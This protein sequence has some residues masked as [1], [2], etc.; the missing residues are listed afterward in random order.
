MS[1][2]PMPTAITADQYDSLLLSETP[3]I[4]LRA[5]VEFAK[6]AF[7]GSVSLP[8][9]TDQER[10][11]IGTRYKEQGQDAAIPE[12]MGMMDWE[13]V[14]ALSTG[15]YIKCWSLT[16]EQQ[17]SRHCCLP[18]ISIQKTVSFIMQ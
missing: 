4:D 7:T 14:T 13:L 5:P 11:L 16:R 6:G 17:N 3:M 9:M 15:R 2:K 1:T 18:S 10:E 12:R 8:L